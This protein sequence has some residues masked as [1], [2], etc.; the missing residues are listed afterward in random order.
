MR[1]RQ[2]GENWANDVAVNI[3]QAAIAAVVTKREPFVIDAEE[4]QDRGMHVVSFHRFVS[5]PGEFV[6]LAVG[7]AALDAGAGYPLN[8]RAAIV[9]AAVGAL[10]EGIAAELRAPHHERIFEQ[11]TLFQIGQQCGDRLID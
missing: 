8:H 6:A 5:M 3:C 2:S 9:I 1:A 11:A 4:M 7:D 10:A